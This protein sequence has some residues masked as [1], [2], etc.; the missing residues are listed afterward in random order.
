M[1]LYVLDFDSVLQSSSPTERHSIPTD[2][3]QSTDYCICVEHSFA[4]AALLYQLER[5]SA[6]LRRTISFQLLLSSLLQS[7]TAASSPTLVHRNTSKVAGTHAHTPDD[8]HEYHSFS[9]PVSNAP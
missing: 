9:P 8:L 4:T 5:S 1:T 2:T 3:K 7:I 6:L